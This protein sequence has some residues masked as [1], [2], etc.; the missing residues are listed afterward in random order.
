MRFLKRLLSG[1]DSKEDSIV[2]QKAERRIEYLRETEGFYE[3]SHQNVR[4]GEESAWSSQYFVDIPEGK[5]VTTTIDGE[6]V[7]LENAIQYYED[8]S[9]SIRIKD[10]E[11]VDIFRGNTAVKLLFAPAN[12]SISEPHYLQTI[13]ESIE[14]NLQNPGDMA[15]K[16]F[17]E[18]DTMFKAQLM[19]YFRN[20]EGYAVTEGEMDGM[21][22]IKVEKE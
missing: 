20:M 5:N 18:A 3:W 9:M 2:N 16:K 4:V 12:L 1:S 21:P 14:A 8:G 17:T 7:S 15:V 11:L 13:I 19:A 22:M 10:K 6:R